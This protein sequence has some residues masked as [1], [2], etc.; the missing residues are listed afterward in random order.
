M[1]CSLTLDSVERSVSRLFSCGYASFVISVN[2]EEEVDMTHSMV[3]S[4]VRR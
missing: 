2:G 4:Q 3:L 1:M